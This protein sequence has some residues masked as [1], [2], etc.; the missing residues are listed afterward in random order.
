MWSVSCVRSTQ[1]PC[2]KLD[3]LKLRLNLQS[4]DALNKVGANSSTSQLLEG[5]ALLP[6][7]RRTFL[8]S[9]SKSALVLSLDGVLTL[10]RPFKSRAFFAAAEEPLKPDAGLGVSFINV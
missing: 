5:I 6:P 1:S 7:S 8:H 3:A 2:M 9:L 4:S 10:A